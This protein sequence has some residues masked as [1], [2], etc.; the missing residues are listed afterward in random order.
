M[1]R[2][3]RL[4]LALTC[5]GL[6]LVASDALAQEKWLLRLAIGHG[7]DAAHS[8]RTFRAGEY[9]FLRGRDASSA[10][11]MGLSGG[12]DRFR[13][14]ARE[15]GS[16]ARS[17][18][19]G[20]GAPDRA[21]INNVSPYVSG[22]Y[23]D[24]GSAYRLDITS[25]SPETL[26]P[27]ASRYLRD[28]RPV[29]DEAWIVVRN[30]DRPIA[31]PFPDIPMNGFRPGAQRSWLEDLPALSNSLDNGA[32]RSWLEN[33][34]GLSNSVDNFGVRSL[35]SGRTIG[36]ADSLDLLLAAAQRPTRPE[37]ANFLS[38]MMATRS[39]RF[40]ISSDE[41]DDAEDEGSPPL[42]EQQRLRIELGAYGN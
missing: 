37:G 40:V 25:G 24:W 5:L 12:A 22:D 1:A 15:S 6:A 8:G 11:H 16:A 34:P 4:P 33:L 39:A 27:G 38:L 30:H 2:F 41:E 13:W 26:G 36:A 35:D 28:M 10:G 14:F 23:A 32:P 29:D 17:G 3:I 42:F 7:D 9:A 20:I 21:W 18:L 19:A 31:L